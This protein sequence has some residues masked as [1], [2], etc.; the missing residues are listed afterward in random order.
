[1]PSK[2]SLIDEY[3]S[4]VTPEQRAALEVV[5]RAIRSA[6]PQ[7]T[8]CISYGMPAFEL[9]KK[10]VAFG[11]TA[12]H[13]AFF[14]MSGTMVDRFSAELE[15]FDTSKGT[16]RFQPEKPLSVALIKK[17]VK[18]RIEEIGASTSTKPVVKRSAK[19]KPAR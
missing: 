3:L 14:P 10:L 11:A 9:G 17:I 6:A 12:K 13:C 5:R 7:A 18:A 16:I 8:E 1:M 15:G 19:K 4:R 2:P